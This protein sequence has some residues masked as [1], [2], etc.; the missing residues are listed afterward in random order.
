M[1]GEWRPR[2][3]PWAI[4]M[5]VTLATFMEVLDT[6]VAN[7]SLPHI[8]GS[9]SADVDSSTWILTS[10]LMANAIVLPLSGWL[11]QLV[12]RKRF[13]LS[14]VAIFTTSSF[15]CGLA[16]N[17]TTLIVLRI[18]QGA[19]GGGLQPSE[20]SILAATCPPE[21]RGMAFAV[22]GMAV[23]LAPAI[24]PTL[25]GFITDNASWRWIFFINVPV[26]IVALILSSRILEDPPYAQARRGIPIDYIGVGLLVTGMAALQFVLDK[27][28]REDWFGSPLIAWLTVLCVVALIALVIW[29]W[30]QSHPV[31]DLHLLRARNFAV[32]FAMMFLLGM[33]LYATTVLLPVFVQVL[34]GYT[35]ERAGMLLS[36]GGL[37]VILLLPLVGRLLG[38]IDA[39]WLIAFGFIATGASL[40]HMTA[41]TLHIDFATLVYYRMYQSVGLAFLFVPINTVSYVGIAPEKNNHVSAMINMARNIGGSIGIA[42]GTTLIARRTQLHQSRLV[43]YAT[44]YRGAFR[45]ALD[46]LSA[47]LGARGISPPDAPHRA[48]ALLYGQIGQQ[49][50]VLAYI[51]VIWLLGVIALAALPLVFLLRRSKPGAPMH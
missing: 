30:R 34:L 40:F 42:F 20:Q 16:P 46:H 2:H 8:A 11:S 14:C 5:T 12:G 33:V 38:K 36:P 51:D 25:G 23:V 27:G 19:G 39:R 7:V 35:A 43:D 18:V 24:G 37:V 32:S 48:L 41:L 31:L 13:Y 1:T 17:L 50:A 4:A 15:L 29:E 3:N 28:Q 44:R 47:L 10:Y 21:K 6:S 22:Y 45:G 49:S 26:G 9:L